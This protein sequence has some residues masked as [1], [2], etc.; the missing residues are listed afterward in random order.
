MIE[1]VSSSQTHVPVRL[2]AHQRLEPSRQA[3]LDVV[4]ELLV[5]LSIR[6]PS[7]ASTT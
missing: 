6:R 1:S 5:R 4:G 7:P 3:K 2:P